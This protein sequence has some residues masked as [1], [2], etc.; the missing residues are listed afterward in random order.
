MNLK[1]RGIWIAAPVMELA[2][3][4][5]GPKIQTKMTVSTSARITRPNVPAQ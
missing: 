2:P 3:G 4:I 1:K 5:V